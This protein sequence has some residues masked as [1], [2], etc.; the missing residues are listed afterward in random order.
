MALQPG[1]SVWVQRYAGS[2]ARHEGVYLGPGTPITSK[3]TTIGGPQPRPIPRGRVRLLSDD[4]V[5]DVAF[6][7]IDERP[8]P[9]GAASTPDS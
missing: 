7:V 4:K 5:I 3:G 9:P 8:P 1:Q 2:D 6:D